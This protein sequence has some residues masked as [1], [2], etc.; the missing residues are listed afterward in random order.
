MPAR[1]DLIHQLSDDELTDLIEAEHKALL[2]AVD[3]AY[4]H[5]VH[6]DYMQD[7][8]D[9]KALRFRERVAARRKEQP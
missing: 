2:E 3:D 6:A 4:R 9:E 1:S 7:L 8:L 5:S